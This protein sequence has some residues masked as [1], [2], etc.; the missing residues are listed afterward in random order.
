[1]IHNVLIVFG[2]EK[3]STPDISNLD[4]KVYLH[5]K[6]TSEGGG[7]KSHPWRGQEIC[8]LQRG[9]PRVL[10]GTITKVLSSLWPQSRELLTVQHLTGLI[11]TNSE[12]KRRNNLERV[13]E[14]K[15]RRVQAPEERL[16]L[17]LEAAQPS[18]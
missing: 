16:E 5:G 6:K 7:K 3:A 15:G 11:Q 9:V 12:F 13:W 17:H 10:M 8:I 18:V 14:K 4:S 1:M 2:Q